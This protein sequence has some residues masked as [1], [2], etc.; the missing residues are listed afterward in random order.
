MGLVTPREDDSDSEDDDDAWRSS[1]KVAARSV[2]GKRA[3][4]KSAFYEGERGSRTLAAWRVQNSELEARVAEAEARRAV[5]QVTVLR[6][7]AWAVEVFR[8]LRG[9]DVV[10]T[11]KDE[12]FARRSEA[13]A[14]WHFFGFDAENP[15]RLWAEE[16]GSEGQ[17][18][19]VVGHWRAFR[20]LYERS[21]ARHF[22]ELVPEGVPC[23]AYF[24]LE[25]AREG[26]ADALD[27]DD[28]TSLWLAAFA[29]RLEAECY[30]ATRLF[31]EHAATADAMGFYDIVPDLD[32]Q[33]RVE[34]DGPPERAAAA[35][36]RLEAAAA[37]AAAEATE[38]T[39]ALLSHV[40][41]VARRRAAGEAFS[42]ISSVDHFLQ[43]D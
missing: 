42:T 27:G 41:G 38:D 7:Q 16:I 30:E 4:S 6:K 36:P 19:Y 3:L 14:A 2:Q 21:G 23:R 10:E 1:K 17:R 11:S 40:A 5:G 24:D 43:L 28:L 29:A 13:R 26:G 35:V 37:A 12:G 9:E 8:I 39:A 33:L 15:V 18:R 22:Y 25:F 32:L 31:R 34:L 20:E